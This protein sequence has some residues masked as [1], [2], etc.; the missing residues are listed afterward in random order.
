MAHVYVYKVRDGMGKTHAGEIEAESKE[1]V[2]ERLRQT[3]YFITKVELK[4]ES[5]TVGETFAKWS[6]V[7]P[8]DLAIFFRQFAT[9]ASSGL[10]L[11]KSLNILIE[12][13]EKMKLRDSLE[14]MRRDVES[15]S[16]LSQ[17]MGKHRSVFPMFVM[18]MVRAGEAGGFLD[19]V[20]DRLAVTFENDHEMR[21][22]VKGAVRYPLIVLGFA[23]LV[24]VLMLTFII[25]NFM[26][27]FETMDIQ[28]PLPTRIVLG[29]SDFLKS[30][31]LILALLAV[32]LALLAVRYVRSPEGRARF[33]RFVLKIPVF[34]ELLLKSS[35]AK[36]SRSL[37]TLLASGVPIIQ[38]L[39]I[40]QGIA[41]NAVVAGELAEVSNGVREGDAM[42]KHLERSRVFT[43]MMI[44]MIAIGEETG[45]LENML[46]KVADFYDKETKYMT[47]NMTSLIEPFLIVI[48]GVIIGGIMLSILLPIFEVYSQMGS[49]I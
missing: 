36:V 13:T 48:L 4:L 24:V 31:F 41:G 18:A 7:T 21:E 25:P 1:L 46:V 6:T 17:A 8:K 14:D 16:S 11:L 27:L 43:P 45:T 23:A 47:D 35:L 10:P 26:L 29:I 19:D 40:T 15:G 42:A 28:M 5:P 37:G 22:K 2:V 12:Q 44:N 33:D 3:G 9:M 38:A 49:G 34:G 32:L 39:E 30:Y 20:M